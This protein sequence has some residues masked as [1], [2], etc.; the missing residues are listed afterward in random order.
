MDDDGFVHTVTGKALKGEILAVSPW[1]EDDPMKSR[2][3]MSLAER[4]SVLE[5]VARQHLPGGARA[6]QYPESVIWADV[7]VPVW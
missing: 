1:V 6:N 5:Q 2:A 7:D 3:K 4:R